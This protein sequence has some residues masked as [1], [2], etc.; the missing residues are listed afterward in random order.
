MPPA[1]ASHPLNSYVVIINSQVVFSSGTL[2]E[3]CAFAKGRGEGV[4]CA[5]VSEVVSFSEND[6][7]APRVK[8]PKNRK[9]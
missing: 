3:S 1:V 2:L 5:V 6:R 8:K 7:P 9:K 4:I